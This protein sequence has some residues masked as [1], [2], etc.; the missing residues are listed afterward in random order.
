MWPKSPYQI[1]IAVAKINRLV[2]H[3]GG[4]NHLTT[5]ALGWPIL[6]NYLGQVQWATDFSQNARRG[7]FCQKERKMNVW[8]SE[9]FSQSVSQ[10]VRKI[11]KIRGLF[12]L[13]VSQSTRKFSKI[14]ALF[15]RSIRVSQP[16]SFQKSQLFFFS[17]SESVRQ[18][19]FK[20]QSYFFSVYQSRSARIF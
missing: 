6:P 14:N 19:F 9:L 1:C 20:N 4:W 2:W 13:S 12:S 10:I 11:S 7:T 3:S 5:L 15:F 16:K 18:K 8:K 17:L